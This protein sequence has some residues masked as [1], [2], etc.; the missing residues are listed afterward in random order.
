MKGIRQKQ[1]YHNAKQRFRKDDSGGF[2][3]PEYYPSGPVPPQPGEAAEFAG[4]VGAFS[5]F[6]P[7]PLC[8]TLIHTATAPYQET[9]LP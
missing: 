8:G 5:R 4:G 3:V 9:A 1:Y 7:V 6:S 2:L